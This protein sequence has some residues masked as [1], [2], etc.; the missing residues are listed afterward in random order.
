MSEKTAIELI[1]MMRGVVS[2]GTGT[3]V[4]AQFGISA[5]IAGKTGTTQYNTD[6][7]FILMHPNLVAGSWIG[8]NDARVTMRSNYWGQGGHDALLVV[9]D[10]FRSALMEKMINAKAKFHRPKQR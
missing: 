9:G 5:D 10:F 8:F 3:L 4:K 2:H 6:G 7:W 1:D